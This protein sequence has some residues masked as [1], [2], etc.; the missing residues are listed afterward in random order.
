TRVAGLTEIATPLEQNNIL[1]TAQYSA[2]EYFIGEI[3]S[4]HSDLFSLGV[5]TYQ[6]LSGRFPYGANVARATTR[7]AQR[8]LKYES[9]LDDERTIPAWVDETIR[10]AVN[11]DPYRRYEKLSEF[12][13][14]LRHPN[15]A[16]VNKTR[17]PLVER[18]PVL[19]WKMVS[20][21]LLLII[22]F[23]ISNNSVIR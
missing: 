1:G 13:F 10:K 20:F 22:I 15:K 11:P 4:T 19:F 23:L 9:V 14:D 7:A 12:I 17:P 3:G 2:P 21:I 5:I 18:S 16:F 6:M 8:K